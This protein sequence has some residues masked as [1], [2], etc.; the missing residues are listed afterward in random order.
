MK[1][2]AKYFALLLIL[3]FAFVAGEIVSLMYVGSD[4]DENSKNYLIRNK[5]KLALKIQE[6]L[7]KSIENDQ[8]LTLTGTC[9]EDISTQEIKDYLSKIDSLEMV[10][11]P[12]GKAK[13]ELKL[14]KMTVK[15]IYKVT[16]QSNGVKINSIVNLSKDGNDWKIENGEI[17][18]NK[19]CKK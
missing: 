2:I 7:R 1:T 5:D 13:V 10:G 19:P 17:S 18:I 14:I 4:V 8:I 15:A 16:F 9:E 11:E 3:C 12:A 6:G